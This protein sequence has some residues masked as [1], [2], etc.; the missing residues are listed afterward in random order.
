MKIKNLTTKIIG[1]GGVAVL[2]NESAIVPDEA[3][4]SSMVK[5]FARTGKISISGNTDPAGDSSSE[6]PADDSPA[7]DPPA[8]DGSG[9]DGSGTDG[10]EDKK[11]PLSRMNKDELEAECKALGIEVT[12]KDTNDT[13]RDKIKAA[14]AA[15]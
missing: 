12:D 2:P 3:A 8:D 1:I 6:P 10:G 9:A 5:H 11:K 7:N 15:E 13:L 4:N 14:T